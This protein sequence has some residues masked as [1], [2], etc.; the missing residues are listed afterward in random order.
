MAPR[1]IRPSLL[2]RVYRAVYL[3][4]FLTDKITGLHQ[5]SW[6][7]F[8]HSAIQFPQRG[9][10]GSFWVR[11]S[12]SENSGFSTLPEPSPGCFRGG[13]TLRTSER[14]LESR[15]TFPHSETT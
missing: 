14:G 10:K 12:R 7:I 2:L 11:R 4:P 13:P 5:N 3:Q 8:D 9:R 1:H 6:V 15:L